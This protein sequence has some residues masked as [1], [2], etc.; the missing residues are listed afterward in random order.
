MSESK[1]GRYIGA[2]IVLIILIVFFLDM[3]GM[4]GHRISPGKTEQTHDVMKNMQTSEVI[5][6]EIDEFE[7]A[8][9]TVTSRK[10]TIISSKVP[11]HVK[12]VH[13]RPGTKVVAGDLLIELDDR[14]LRAKL[15]QVKSGLTAAQASQ[16]QA[17]SSY[18][19][20]RNLLKSGA[21]TRSEFEAA[22][23]Q[24]ETATA[25]V[26]EAEQTLQE[27]SV[28]L[29]YTEI[30]APYSGIVVD[31][32]IDKGTLA[33]PGIPLIRL[34]D[35]DQLRLEVFVPESRRNSIDIGKTLMIRIDTVDKDIPG[36]VDEVV[37]SSDPRSR[38]FLVRITMAPD[39]DIQTGMF[40]R[41]YL[42]VERKRMILVERD[43]IYRVGQ[44]EMVR[45]LDNDR[46][47]TRLIR[48]GMIFDDRIE[49]LSGLEP[50]EL[51]LKRSV[52][53]E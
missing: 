32:M 7:T 46:P 16:K 12:K 14:D 10:E 18:D 27:L 38:S 50:G 9:G 40:G 23:A 42:P 49:I 24:F 39:P 33:A 36:K 44:L 37:P 21:A 41:C 13:V 51:V 22:E 6:E 8:V 1:K 28:M 20:Y 26:L 29:D 17:E 31:K 2:G 11:A 25:K 34:E 3:Q 48:T 30:R 5:S 45:V 15:G 53:E 35:P 52:E 19:R 43:A 47:E 4:L